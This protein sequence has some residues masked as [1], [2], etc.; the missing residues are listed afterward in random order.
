VLRL[1]DI[2]VR[3]GG[4]SLQLDSLELARGD[5]LVILGPNGAGKTVLLETIA[6]L[7]PVERGRVEFAAPAG[8]GAGAG[9]AGSATATPGR[10]A[11][12]G[13]WRDVTL[14]PPEKREVGFVY[15][16][17]LLFPHL[18]V[19]GNI[20]FGLKGLA[21]AERAGRVRDAAA[22]TGVEGLLARRVAGLSGGEQQ[23][24]ALARALAI[25]PRLLL[26]DEPLAA[27]DRSARR[28]TAGEVRRL[29]RDL[30]VTV[31][32]VT[33][34]L[35]E[36]L[37]LGDRIAVL[38]GGRLL[39]I[40]TAEELLRAPACRQVAELA[41]CENLLHATVG[42]STVVIS[43]GPT[44][45]MASGAGADTADG[46]VTV[47][48]RAE[49]LVLRPAPPVPAAA[50]ALGTAVAAVAGDAA[51]TNG[52]EPNVFPAVVETMEP[53]PAH[54]VVK[55]RY[56]GDRDDAGGA[57]DGAAAS[58]PAHAGPVGIP[59]PA[60]G[61]LF[62]VFVMPPKLARLGLVPGM[63]VAVQVDP[64]RVAVCAP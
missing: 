16:D 13:A 12:A 10:A 43:G 6:G 55:V 8:A 52:G 34:S 18:S 46:P 32:H 15:Q 3:L 11:T 44:L 28:A 29:C 62:T 35:D 37:S 23:K 20:G 42:G 47:A 38:A 58:S 17:Y 1:T 41:G 26:L 22:L 27:L 61:C 2:L 49:D 7:H 25:R 31:L 51:G 33:H 36:A 48:L 40:G 21:A 19:S 24:V 64:E 30:G 9:A 45:F 57:P 60:S 63:P 5:Y 4:F 54:W 53:G 56:L 59:S 14:W 39:Q 50:A